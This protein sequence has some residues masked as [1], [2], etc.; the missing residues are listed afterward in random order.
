MAYKIPFSQKGKT[1]GVREFAN[2]ATVLKNVAPVVDFCAEQNFIYD[3]LYG[4]YPVLIECVERGVEDMFYGMANVSESDK[5]R[6]R[7]KLLS[8][9][10]R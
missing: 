7:T 3:G 4:V 8:T 2:F 5:N 10:Y 1:V 9:H 6:A